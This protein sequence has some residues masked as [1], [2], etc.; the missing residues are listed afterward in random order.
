MST[1][2]GQGHFNRMKHWRA[3]AS[4]SDK[5]AV[6]YRGGIVLAAIVDWLKHLSDTA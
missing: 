5:Y 6:V 4:R 2:R 3:L 1:D